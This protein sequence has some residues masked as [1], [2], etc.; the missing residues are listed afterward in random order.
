GTGESQGNLDIM[1]WSADLLTVI[2]FVCSVEE[3]DE[4]RLT[5]LGF[6]AGAAVSIYVAAQDTRVSSLAACACPADFGFLA[7]PETAPSTIQH[8]RDV[9]LIR[10]DRFPLSNE[11]W[12]DG[13][14]A[15]SPVQWIDRISPRPLLL[16][17]GDADELVPLEHAHR[18]YRQ[19]K[20]PKELVVIPGA[21]HRLR[22][23][24][25]AMAA[26]LRWLEAR[27]AT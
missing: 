19:A 9:G 18:L 23:E 16:V 24:Q 10:D 8:F 12:I 25:K 22:L 6:S 1:G 3:A 26:V 21:R 2:D 15:I 13:F 20:E 11:A 7:S 27:Y 5:L 14:R 17:H 4:S